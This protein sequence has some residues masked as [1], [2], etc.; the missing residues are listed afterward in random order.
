MRDTFTLYSCFPRF[1]ITTNEA[2]FFRGMVHLTPH[3][4][5]TRHGDNILLYST[6]NEDDEWF[7]IIS[8]SSKVEPH[9]TFDMHGDY[10]D[11]HIVQET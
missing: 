10:V 3:F 7:D 6:K 11:C 5:N 2:L 1:T 8:D 9:I 4:T